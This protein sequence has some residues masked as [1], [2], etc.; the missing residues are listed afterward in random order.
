MLF[1][2]MAPLSTFSAK[3]QIAYYLGLINKKQY[4]DLKI[5][6][7]V[8]NLFAHSIN[9]TTFETLDIKDR[10]NQLKT[11]PIKSGENPKDHFK[12]ASTIL[13]LLLFTKTEEIVR[14]KPYK[15][16]NIIEE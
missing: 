3:I 7:K 2:G 14:I 16:K 4:H 8:R 12:V 13:S 9:R 1:Q 5:I 15:F 6:K 11:I 10:C